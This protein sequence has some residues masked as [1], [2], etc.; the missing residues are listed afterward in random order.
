MISHPD[1]KRQPA[2][3]IVA[4]DSFNAG[5]EKA[6]NCVAGS[7]CAAGALPFTLSGRLDTGCAGCE[8]SLAVSAGIRVNVSGIVD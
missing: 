6:L 3:Y 8:S 2:K 1:I 5:L 7:I 4:Q